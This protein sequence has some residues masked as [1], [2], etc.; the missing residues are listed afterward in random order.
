MRIIS[1]AYPPPPPPPLTMD[2][3]NKD[4][5]D[6]QPHHD[7]PRVPRSLDVDN[8]SN[9]P[10]GSPHL[11]LL[12]NAISVSPNTASNHTHDPVQNSASSAYPNSPATIPHH[13]ERPPSDPATVRTLLSTPHHPVTTDWRVVAATDHRRNGEHASPSTVARDGQVSQ[14]IQSRR[15]LFQ[16]VSSGLL[17]QAQA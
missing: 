2:D 16:S 3:L 12:I 10:P 17:K 8:Q 1:H 7:S 9:P 15:S 6:M 4:L 14:Y 5:K 11:N 13:H